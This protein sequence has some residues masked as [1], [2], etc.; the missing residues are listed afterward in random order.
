[1]DPAALEEAA[2]LV[3]AA[4][5][6]DVP[7]G[8]AMAR[9]ETARRAVAWLTLA[10]YL[11]PSG[12]RDRDAAAGDIWLE[13]ARAP[14]L[15][16][17]GLRHMMADEYGVALSQHAAAVNDIEGSNVAVTIFETVL[18]V[19]PDTHPHRARYC[20][21][22]GA[23]LW[24]RHRISGDVADL[25]ASARYFEEAVRA[26]DGD[27]PDRFAD[28]SQVYLTRFEV[29]RSQQD[30][31]AAIDAAER[32]MRQVREDHQT[33]RLFNVLGSCYK[34]RFVVTRSAADF[35]AALE[36][37]ASA[38]RT[39]SRDTPGAGMILSNAGLICHDRFDR[40]H[41]RPDIDAAIEYLVR[42]VGLT[43]DGHTDLPG[44][45]SR[46]AEAHRA[47][48]VLA[49]LPA[50]L[51]AAITA[52]LRS[53]RCSPPGHPDTGQRLD[54]LVNDWWQRYQDSADR[55]D[56]D[57]VIDVSEQTADSS[58][59][60]LARL[61]AFFQ[62]RWQ[63]DPGG[64]GREDL[65]AAIRN[66]RA[67][68]GTSDDDDPQL[69]A[70][71]LMLGISYQNRY[72]GANDP[73]D[74]DAAIEAFT[75]AVR[76]IADQDHGRARALV[77]LGAACCIRSAR[78]GEAP[79]KDADSIRAIEFLNQ[80]IALMAADDPEASDHLAKLA[81][82]HRHRYEL[83]GDRE[84]ID[85]AVAW[86]GQAAELTP[87][88]HPRYDARHG[89]LAGALLGRFG[90]S[91]E[92]SDID[93]AIGHA[94]IAVQ[95]CPAGEEGVVGYQYGLAQLYAAR[96][97]GSGDPADIAFAIDVTQQ[98][99]RVD[100]E[101]VF[102]Q[103]LLG[104]FFRQ[105]YEQAGD[106]ADIRE[107]F[108]LSS[109]AVDMAVGSHPRRAQCLSE[110]AAAYWARF[111]SAGRPGDLDRS[112][113]ILIE[114]VRCESPGDR[115]AANAIRL[116]LGVAY[117]TRFGLHGALTDI[118]AAIDHISAVVKAQPADHNDRHLSLDNLGV[119]YHHRAK[120]TNDPRDLDAAIDCASRA[121]AATPEGHPRLPGYLSNLA[122]FLSSRHD[123]TRDIADLYAAIDSGRRAVASCPDGSPQLPVCLNNLMDH[124][125]ERYESSNDPTDLDTA[126]D[127][128]RRA[129]PLAGDGSPVSTNIY[130]HLGRAFASRVGSVTAALP[131]SD[132]AAA[133]FG[134]FFKPNTSAGFDAAAAGESF[135][136][137]AA[138]PVGDVSLRVRSLA[139]L[140]KSLKWQAEA[141]PAYRSAIELLAT[142]VAPRDL[143]WGDQAHRL[144]QYF[145]LVGEAVAAHLEDDAETAIELA[146]RGRGI[147]L[148]HQLDAQS[149]LT[150]LRKLA[151]AL[152]EEFVQVRG[153]L[154]D[155]GSA[156][157][158]P[159][160]GPGPGIWSA[161]AASTEKRRAAGRRYA[162]LLDEIRKMTG[163]ERFLQPPVV[164]DLIRQ[165]A[166][167]GPVVMVNTSPRR[168][169]AIIMRR[170]TAPHVLPL[171][172]LSHQAVSE[173]AAELLDVVRGTPNMTGLIRRRQ[174]IADTLGWLWDTTGKPV[175]DYLGYS[176]LSQDIPPPR[177]WWVPCGLLT[178][179]PIHAAGLP[180]G[181]SMLDCATS[182]YAPTL[183]ALAVSQDARPLLRPQ[184]QLI[185]AMPI[186][187]ALPGRPRPAD[188]T[189]TAVEAQ[190]LAEKIP[191][192]SL[193][194]GG[195]ATIGNVLAGLE[196]ASWVHFACHAS[197]DLNAPSRGRLLLHDGDLD[198]TRIS[199]MRLNQ[200][201][202]IYLS[203][204]G[205]A[206][207]GVLQ[208]DEIIT[209][210]S[211][212]QLAGF[213]HVIGT[214]WPVSDNPA[215]LT[216]KMFYDEL[217]KTCD[218]DNS[219]GILNQVTRKLRA[220]QPAKPDRWSQ[221]I[222]I[223]P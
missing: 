56:L 132:R 68:V 221:F 38:A 126:I 198:I 186:T 57:S 222:H 164:N 174:V 69:P 138:N 170:D 191:G 175:I 21:H 133:R 12:G 28:L 193:L 108:A 112:M 212:C 81:E 196:E 119:A 134:I 153:D 201:D 13:F 106:P 79:D 89:D 187:P 210:A 167:S 59:A 219:A 53:V 110:L 14:D 90:R 157:T 74:L 11:A 70:R 203:A 137:A 209:V 1:M 104:L 97:G 145:G 128:G 62:V 204:C 55:R 116:N 207:G 217:L 149:D 44:Y 60:G 109:K 36:A 66:S 84:D 148:A 94:R 33:A 178:M 99:M 6:P 54:N 49:G 105:R 67:A 4:A 29:I 146:E 34:K 176:D 10:R 37:H 100:A 194:T 98:V 171:P 117:S 111:R 46:L 31:D 185:V 151:P 143:D 135:R 183:R 8:R 15:F 88:A 35:D 124:H 64:H 40:T 72:E 23:A 61:A 181:P 211:A 197:A 96:Y 118:D 166:A 19:T 162:E 113:E 200:A 173:H 177:I 172:D 189:G 86:Y 192:V 154:N 71:L 63:H 158:R 156:R 220:A 130:Y 163:M 129:L 169:D 127:L 125:L 45:L 147:I 120:R 122:A 188:L 101:H 87:E 131:E 180:G 161:G 20:A 205:T 39:V 18:A 190:A 179:L 168:C 218:T 32:G 165:A 160:P 85:A 91:G 103:Y 65:D 213:R 114:A 5:E 144:G 208:A 77:L 142:Q 22:I 83:T 42:A 115:D 58:A 73:Q 139:R 43:P 214:L 3:R 2:A 52:G 182:S 75:R 95:R 50:D 155:P 216:A 24:L 140:G 9:Q 76:I 136:R 7:A 51:D 141:R 48:H 159:A 199:R 26:D 82:A 25:D 27:V 102:G 30:L 41:D 80:G 215:A 16:S 223:G 195:H 206:Q 78:A 150:D 152:A 93:R 184:H 123:L 17:E 121:V 92:L 47:R 202:L 107:A